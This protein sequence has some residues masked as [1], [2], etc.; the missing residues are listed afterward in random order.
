MIKRECK[1]PLFL[2]N[3]LGSIPTAWNQ[4]GGLV[5]YVAIDPFGIRWSYVY[6]LIPKVWIYLYKPPHTEDVDLYI[7]PYHPEGVDLYISISSRRCRFIYKPPHT[8]GVDLYIYNPPHTE[9]VDRYVEN[10]APQN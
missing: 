2:S 1:L 8:E 10:D 4:G 6:H 5:F 7:I 3:R 9:G